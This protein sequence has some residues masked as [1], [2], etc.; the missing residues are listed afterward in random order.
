M[1]LRVSRAKRV[2]L[3]CAFSALLSTQLQSCGAESDG[4]SG[5]EGADSFFDAGLG[6]LATASG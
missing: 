3:V 4:E 2:F 5:S 1:A 6:G